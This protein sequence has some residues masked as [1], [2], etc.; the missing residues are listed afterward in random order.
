MNSEE[1][2]E[3]KLKKI[4]KTSFI[5]AGISILFFIALMFMLPDSEMIFIKAIPICIFV[6]SGTFGFNILNH[7]KKS[8][9]LK[10][11]VF[12]GLVFIIVGMFIGLFYTPSN[13]RRTAYIDDLNGRSYNSQFTMYEGQT[14]VK[15]DKIK[16]LIRDIIA[17]NKNQESD[18]TYWIQVR[19]R[20][21]KTNSPLDVAKDM[22]KNSNDAED[23]NIE[24]LE[25]YNENIL[26][27]LKKI[28]ASK[29]Y[30]VEYGY[31]TKTGYVV[32]IAIVLSE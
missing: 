22:I 32:E 28:K 19:V 15:G 7:T 8:Q 20:D 11:L 30:A 27:E 10:V 5:I 13:K 14:K 21:E 3:E 31:D 1:Y 29:M 12:L 18:T 16:S 17:Q 23:L 24:D 6:I 2:L 4:Y 25:E 26:N 9:I